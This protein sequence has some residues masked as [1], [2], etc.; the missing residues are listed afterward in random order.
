MVHVNW[1]PSPRELRRWALTVAPALAAVGLL[2]RFVLSGFFPAGHAMAPYMWAFAAI[3]LATA[4]PGTRAGLPAYLAWTAFTWA[5]G[6]ALGT[7]ALGV[8]F[9]GVITPLGVVS[10]LAGRDRLRLRDP[11]SASG[12]VPL[13]ATPHDPERQF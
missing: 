12:W 3:A 9:F 7:V 2:F 6:T 1:N 10:R 4:G 13:P 8:V 5:V 11:G